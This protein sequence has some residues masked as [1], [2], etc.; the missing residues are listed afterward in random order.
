MEHGTTTQPLKEPMPCSNPPVRYVMEYS[1][2]KIF[3]AGG[4]LS[5]AAAFQ[6]Y[7]RNEGGW[8]K[9]VK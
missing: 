1:M 2:A 9:K 3:F 4:G 7:L 6:F 5:F 8:P